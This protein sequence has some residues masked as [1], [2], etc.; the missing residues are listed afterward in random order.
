MDAP[1]FH[2]TI[3]TRDSYRTGPGA[4]G[5]RTARFLGRFDT[6]Y[7]LRMAALV[8][9]SARQ[10]HRGTYGMAEWERS[11]WVAAQIVEQCGGAIEITGLA[12]HAALRGPRV[13]VAN[14]M[15]M[16]ETFLLPCLLVPVGPVATVVKESLLRYPYFGAILRS[17]DP[18]TVTR[19]SPREDLRQVLAEGRAALQGG[20][21]VL[22]FPQATRSVRFVASAFNSIGVKLATRAGVPLVPIAV[23]TDF[24]GLGWPLRD[25]GRVDRRKPVRVRFGPSIAPGAHPRDMQATAVAFLAGTLAGWGVPVDAGPAPAEGD[26][27]S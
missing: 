6:W 2:D 8:V 21:S 1:A 12:G 11:S 3:L 13:Y 9:R 7:Y 5:S 14:H 25:V 19:N 15:S 26:G 16:L 4:S 22:V 27:D 17:L 18:I 10:A 20:R 23:R 24:Q